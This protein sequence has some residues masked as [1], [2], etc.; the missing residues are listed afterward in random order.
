MTWQKSSSY[1]YQSVFFFNFC[2]NEFVPGRS[3]TGK[4]K[5]EEWLMQWQCIVCSG[6]IYQNIFLN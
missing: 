4:K 6:K 2:E 5:D 1:V 3:E